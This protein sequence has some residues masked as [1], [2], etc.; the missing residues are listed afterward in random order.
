MGEEQGK[1]AYKQCS[2]C[3]EI[4]CDPWIIEKCLWV[5]AGNQDDVDLEKANRIC[6]NC[7]NFSSK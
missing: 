1:R 3:C 2:N 5:K 7:K 4:G 6:G